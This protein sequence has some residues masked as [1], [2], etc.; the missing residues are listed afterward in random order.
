MFIRI[1][2]VRLLAFLDR[3]IRLE[4]VR[5]RFNVN[6]RADV[7]QPQLDVRP[8]RHVGVPQLGARQLH[9]ACADR[10][11]QDAFCKEDR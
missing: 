7:L 4:E 2:Q 6:S 5:E 11:T 9:L 3:V 1:R 10:L 8:G